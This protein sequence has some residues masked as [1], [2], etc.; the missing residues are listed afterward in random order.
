MSGCSVLHWIEEKTV[1][2]AA[3]LRGFAIT[4]QLINQTFD[5]KLQVPARQYSTDVCAIKNVFSCAQQ[6][7]QVQTGRWVETLD[8]QRE[9]KKFC[10]WLLSYFLE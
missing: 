9:N 5:F 1:D 8:R 2:L 6:Q 7:N 3:T 10:C 4:F